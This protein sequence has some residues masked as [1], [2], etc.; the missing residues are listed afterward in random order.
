[1]YRFILDFIITVL[2]FFIIVSLFTIIGTPMLIFILGNGN[3]KAI[4]LVIAFIISIFIRYYMNKKEG[5]NE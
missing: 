4:M 3:I 2:I 1:M 5:N